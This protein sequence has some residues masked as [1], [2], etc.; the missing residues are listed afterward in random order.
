MHAGVVHNK[1]DCRPV[2]NTDGRSSVL[3]HRLWAFRTQLKLSP[4]NEP[5]PIMKK[6]FISAFPTS[7]FPMW[8]AVVRLQA[9]ALEAIHAIED[10]ALQ[11]DALDLVV[12]RIAYQ[13]GA[14]LD[15]S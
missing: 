5:T 1:P 4:F 2:T 12:N 15:T 7:K 8:V 10:P 3:R 14:R 11:A 9:G 13:R 6:I